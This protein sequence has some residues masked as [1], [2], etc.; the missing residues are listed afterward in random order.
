MIPTAWKRIRHSLLVVA[1][2]STLLSVP[3]ASAQW[4]QW[5]GPSRD[6]NAPDGKLAT[7][8]PEA[9]PT[10]LWSRDLGSGYS[11][12]TAD[13]GL[14]F[15]MYGK[16]KGQEAVAAFK[17]ETGEPVWEHEYEVAYF[18]GMDRKFGTGPRGTPL[19]VGD[20]VF[21]AGISAVL[22]CLDK[23]SG[24]PIWSHDLHKEYGATELFW[25]YSSSPLAVGVL[26]VIPVG[27]KKGVMA[28]HQKDGKPAWSS[29]AAKNGYASPIL[30]KVGG[31]EQIA[32]FMA[33]R[34]MG[35]N[36]VDGKKLWSVNHNTSYDVNASTPIWGP[37][38][39]LFVSSAYGTGSQAI[40]LSRD[41]DKTTA[42]KVWANRKFQVHHGSA[43][44]I[45]DYVYGS[46]GDNGPS[47]FGAVN[48][49]SGEI[50]WRERGLAKCTCVRIGERLVLLGEDGQ[51]ALATPSPTGLTVH[52][53][54]PLLER[55]SWTVPTV[56]G[57][58]LYV[59]DQKRILA[60][61]VG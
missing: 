50:A 35:L 9:G 58:T 6:F 61:Q 40:K 31:Q 15:T 22:S 60:L 44:R 3:M 24:K 25:G 16:G 29:P 53:K 20:R 43:I 17:A 13:D 45:G 19:V 49:Q 51:L 4:P 21:T 7:K 12:I 36:P 57:G 18:D 8:W 37:D 55:V 27:G 34:V 2:A 28:F 11:S 30:I 54:A 38:G 59:R 1:G 56:I 32:A 48:A 41:G 23:K 39:L 46:S 52:S 10:Q 47:F 26:V 14:L 5:G 33:D 42:K